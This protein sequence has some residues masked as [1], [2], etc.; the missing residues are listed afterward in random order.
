[1][2]NQYEQFSVANPYQ[3]QQQEL[4]RRQKMAE[5]LQQQAFEPV[6]SGSYQGIQAPIS[7]VQGL[8][9]VL[10][11]YLSNKNQEGLKQEQK[12]LGEQYKADTSADIQKLIQ[13]LQARSA[14]PEVNQEP[15]ARDFEDNP[16]LAPTFAQMMPDQQKA[17][18]MPAMPAKAMG[19]IDPSL[20]GEFKTPGMQQQAMNMY[21]SQLAPK[22]PVI[23]GEGQIAYNPTTGAEMFKGGA[24]SPFGN[25]NPASFTPD[26]LRAFSAG[27]GKDFSVL[28]P[29]ISADTTARLTQE[30]QLSD[31]AFEGLSANQKASLANEAARLGISSTQLFFDTGMKAGGVPRPSQP[32]PQPNIQ[33]TQ[34]LGQPVPQVNVQAPRP[35]T[36]QPVAPPVSPNQALAS[37]LSPKAQQELQVAQ[38]KEQQLATQALPQVMQQ[39]QTLISSID[40]MI[41]VK[42]ANG[43]VTIP[44]HKGLKDVV[45]TAIPFE[46]KPFQGGSQGADFKA[47]YDQVKG[48][49]F[50]EA[51]QRMK[52]TGAI[53]EIEGTKAT[54][55][56]TE[57]TTAQSPDAFRG[58][59]SRFRDAIQTGMRSAMTKAG[60]AQIPTYNPTTGRVE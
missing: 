35:Q 3:L 52:G 26:S 6:Q 32:V 38:L 18:T 43:K 10:Q 34:P 51:V 15:T 9:K 31:R 27:G 14:T 59:M 37:S 42:D 57:A 46:Y 11:M 19:A 36:M 20:I 49:A 13:G 47:L 24:K 28:V 22:A 1:M 17:M 44:E 12:A 56:L 60:K 23:L 33:A 16:N 2:A 7:P 5:I 8:A 29:A 21:M 41:G 54:A 30:R 39:G 55:A 48:G 40:K 50:L 25:V 53:S 58:A 4:D 45:G